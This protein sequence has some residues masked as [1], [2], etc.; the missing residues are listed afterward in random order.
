MKERLGVGVA[1][2]AHINAVEVEKSRRSWTRPIYMYGVGKIII[3]H[4]KIIP[5]HSE[6]PWFCIYYLIQYWW[7]SY[8]VVGCTH[9]G[10]SCFN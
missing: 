9:V 1:I 2:R 3:V 6:Y 7:L 10:L 8:D 4:D 5:F